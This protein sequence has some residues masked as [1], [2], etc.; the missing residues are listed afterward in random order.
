V[1]SSCLSTP[2][3]LRASGF[4]AFVVLVLVAIGLTGCARSPGIELREWTANIEGREARV[5]LPAHVDAPPHA[6][7]YTLR[8]KA[9]LAPSLR[10]RPLRF[11]V[12]YLPGV[13]ELYV[14]DLA[15]PL[16]EEGGPSVTLG[17]RGASG[18]HE[19]LIPRT[20]TTHET[21]ELRLV[22]THGWRQSSWVDSVPR[23]AVADSP[24][25]AFDAQR[26]VTELSATFALSTMIPIGFAYLLLYLLDRRRVAN[27]WF[28]LQALTGSFLPIFVLGTTQRVFGTWDEAILAG[29]QAIAPYAGL[30][31]TYATFGLG[32]PPKFLAMLVWIS[33][34]AAFVFSSPFD[35][36]AN[37]AVTVTAITITLV[38]HLYRLLGLV[39]QRPVPPNV[40]IL[41]VGWCAVGGSVVFEGPLFLGL[42]APVGAA[43]FGCVG[44][45]TI[46]ICQTMVLVR[47]HVLSLRRADELNRTLRAQ[48]DELET[49]QRENAVLTDELRR[50]VAGRSEE[51]SSTLARVSLA[52]GAPVLSPGEI[53][54]ERFEVVRA[55]G[56]G[57]MGSVYEVVRLV[58]GRSFALKVMDGA[59]QPLRMARFAREGQLGA[60]IVHRNVVGIV[61]VQVSERGYLYLVMEIV[62][63]RSLAAHADRYRDV[64][65]ALSILAQICDG[66]AAI[67]AVGIVH[68]DLKPSN[69]L[70]EGASGIVRITDFGISRKTRAEAEDDESALDDESTAPP[71]KRADLALLQQAN[72]GSDDATTTEGTCDL[73]ATGAI[74][75][76]PLWA[77]PE[78]ARGTTNVGPATDIWGVGLIAHLLLTG[79]R[80]RLARAAGSR[81]DPVV[82]EGL[83]MLL[84]RALADAP[85][86][87]PSAACLADAFRTEMASI[88]KRAS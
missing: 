46:A 45:V 20:A 84:T 64:R 5:F 75:G 34:A 50:Q 9:P 73:T 68:R 2:Y 26:G 37:A 76:T 21:L 47:D 54:D 60:R 32:K 35:T 25:P 15:E 18:A 74:I 27:G 36:L 22:V 11:T 43:R 85:R 40:R 79:A 30:R 41:L 38:F 52:A 17:Y 14:G 67:H 70:V 49:R 55:L 81:L 19:W 1:F 3:A 88:Q 4:S 7:V 13:T 6:T 86:L 87:R 66:L 48:V 58:D 59:P 72:M 56:S 16:R 10:G 69:I 8:T 42:G 12:P 62:R 51:L 77:A 83:A 44:L 63:G 33:C 31:F 23:L 57:G 29:S 71:V 65:W 61:D 28:A 24:D 53:V 39:R 78:I 80:P 82:S